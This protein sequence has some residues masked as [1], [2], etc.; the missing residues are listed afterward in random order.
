MNQLSAAKKTGINTGTRVDGP[1]KSEAPVE[2][3]GKHAIILDG[4]QPSEVMQDFA[5]PSTGSVG[6]GDLH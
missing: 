2:N 6:H 1:A 4:F 3:S 5:G